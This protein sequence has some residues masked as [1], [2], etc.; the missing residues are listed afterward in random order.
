[1]RNLKMIKAKR[2]FF[3]YFILLCLPAT[4]TICAQTSSVASNLI[5]LYPADKSRNINPDTHLKITFPSAPILG[6]KG[7][8]RIYDMEDNRL[9]DEL[10]MSIPAG[11]T[12][13]T[14]SRSN[15]K[16]PYIQVP[17]EY[18]SGKFTNA[19][20]KPGTPS[21]GAL[22]TPNNYQL[23]IIGGFTDGFH[24]YPVIIHNKTATIYPHNNI[25][26]Y[27]KTYYVQIDPGV[28]ILRDTSF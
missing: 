21:G 18:I 8:I 26:E 24:F 23:T 14:S 7:K 15:S 5:G 13:S 12:D 1:M 6:T 27:N 19:N 3:I 2:V 4:L 9:V 22:P 16:P 28:L 10:D 11:P 17:Y 25:L 20:T